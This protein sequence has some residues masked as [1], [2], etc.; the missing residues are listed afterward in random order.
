MSKNIW[1][2][3]SVR[4]NPSVLQT[5]VY[6]KLISFFKL[7]MKL[8]SN[9]EN[10]VSIYE[11][12]VLLWNSRVHTF[13]SIICWKSFSSKNMRTI[14]CLISYLMSAVNLP[15]PLAIFRI[16]SKIQNFNFESFKPEV[17][18]CVNN[19]QTKLDQTNSFYFIR[20]SYIFSLLLLLLLLHGL[21]KRL[22]SFHVLWLEWIAKQ[23]TSVKL[24]NYEKCSFLFPLPNEFLAKKESL[25]LLIQNWTEQQLSGERVEQTHTHKLIHSRQI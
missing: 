4:K 5:V 16:H 13:A 2:K 18:S 1:W 3:T 21:R 14:F 23:A 12:I 20:S 9:E 7:H 10:D 8:L 11:S 25:Q 6:S 19:S 24:R 17:V 15:C 22:N